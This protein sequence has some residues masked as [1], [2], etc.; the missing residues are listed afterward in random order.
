MARP[1]LARPQ[2]AR[3]QLARP[4]LAR[5]QLARPRVARPQLA[6]PRLARP[7]LARRQLARPQPV[8]PS[9]R[10]EHLVRAAPTWAA[11]RRGRGP[12][13]AKAPAGRAALERRCRPS[14][15]AARS[16]TDRSKA[17]GAPIDEP[18]DQPR[19]ERGSRVWPRVVGVGI[20]LLAAGGAWVWQNPG[21][22]QHT[23]GS[24]FP[25]S[26]AQDADAAAIRSLD[27]R[28]TR[29]EQ[30]PP[31]AEL[32]ALTQ[33]VDALEQR[34]AATG[35]P[36]GS[37]ASQPAGDLGSL[38]A[39]LDALEARTK[40]PPGSPGSQPPQSQN[41][42][43][44]PTHRPAAPDLTP[45]Y[46][47]IDAL[48]Q[49]VAERTVD[50]S[51]VA[52]LTARVQQLSTQDDTTELRGKLDQVEHQLS[53]L[54]AS[55]AKLSAGSDQT[56]RVARL[57][58]AEIA[59]ASGHP[60]GPI[61]G[62]PPAL[63]RFETSAPPTQA[64]L[65]LAFPAAASA[66]LKVSQ[67]DTGGKSFLDGVIARLQDSRLITV[68]KGDRVLVG[69]AAA[70]TLAHA[71]ELLE[72]GDLAGAAREVATLT[73]PPAEKMAPWLTDANALVAAREALA[74]LAEHG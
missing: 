16:L 46:A 55:E 12:R 25:G 54:S 34:L 13:S 17:E 11:P 57:D 10:P 71:Q 68:Q 24:L 62:A 23:M 27:A 63:A 30:R 39:R 64:A 7:R 8:Y 22:L 45:L 73:G 28:V 9:P 35:Q 47:R 37:N 38:Q 2:L 41:G 36:T 6:R 61:P 31:P 18:P 42:G 60:L 70:V 26:A 5:P 43:G 49:T 21:F 67:P 52:A 40:V 29:L 69:D 74:S 14:S 20:L 65:R 3:P 32:T 53:G 51:K 1:Q 19:T 44:G 33:R 66:A 4:Q 72:A 50:P 58:A 48:E 15:R 59:L 56:A